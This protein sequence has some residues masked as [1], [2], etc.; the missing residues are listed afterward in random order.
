MY[1]KVK[2]FPTITE[3]QTDGRTHRLMEVEDKFNMYLF[4]L[5]FSQFLSLSQ[6]FRKYFFLE[7]N[8]Q[9][10]FAKLHFLKVTTFTKNNL[11]FMIFRADIS[12]RYMLEEQ[13][14]YC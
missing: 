10:C 7:E 9:R 11:S 12:K 3:G 14:R 2:T 4:S 5:I 8:L 13:I 6:F 1:H